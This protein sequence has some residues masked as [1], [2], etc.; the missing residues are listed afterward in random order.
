M[1]ELKDLL[2]QIEDKFL[3]KENSYDAGVVNIY[4]SILSFLKNHLVKKA[5]ADGKEFIGDEH[6]DILDLIEYLEN[7]YPAIQ[8]Y[9]RRY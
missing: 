8:E 4:C 3:E 1:T 5:F 2:K 9:L 7:A 6:K